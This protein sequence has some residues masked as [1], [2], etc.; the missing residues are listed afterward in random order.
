[1]TMELYPDL[2]VP[3]TP[4]VNI[5]DLRQGA[6]AACATAKL[7]EEHGLDI[8]PTDEDKEVAAT[9][10]TAYAQDPDRV[11]NKVTAKNLAKL[12]PASLVQVRT[13]LDEFSQLVVDQS[14]ELRHLVTNKLILETENPDA[15]VRLKAL[16]LLG[17]ISDVGLFTDRREVTITHQS[18]D[19]LKTRLREKLQKLRIVDVEVR[20]VTETSVSEE[21]GL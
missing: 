9:L 6:I 21:L 16:E 11:N 5:E 10:A 12:T 20:D 18:T 17:K 15:R 19:D 3:L 8:T 4:D 13:I 7:L 2:G 1:M 14:L